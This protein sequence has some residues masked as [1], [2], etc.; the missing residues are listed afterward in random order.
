MS[1]VQPTGLLRKLMPGAI[2]R[3]PASG[4]VVYLTFDDGPTPD[5]T[6]QVLKMLKDANA[7]ATF[8]C[9]GNNIVAHPDLFAQLTSLGHQI[10]NHSFSHKNGWKTDFKSYLTDVEQCDTWVKSGLFRPPYG[11]LSIRQFFNLRKRYRIILW[12]VLSMDYDV[13]LSPNQC[14]KNVL[15]HVRPGSIITFHDS[16]KAWP[17]LKEILPLVLSELARQGYR[18]ETLFPKEVLK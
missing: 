17:R 18:F 3:M 15:S 5:V 7:L 13:K 14:L 16:V 4:K 10:G 6:N 9:I 11:R 2:W 8:F 1:L 12:D